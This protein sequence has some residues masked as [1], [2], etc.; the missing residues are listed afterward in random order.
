[1]VLFGLV[2]NQT[3]DPVWPLHFTYL[4]K[5]IVGPHSIY[6]VFRG[7]LSEPWARMSEPW[8]PACEKKERMSMFHRQ[9]WVQR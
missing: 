1:M 7:R 8:T 4:V 6:V 3:H 5:S 9:S 2:S